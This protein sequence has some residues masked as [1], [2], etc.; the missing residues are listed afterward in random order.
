VGLDAY[1]DAEFDGASA[2][3]AGTCYWAAGRN[4]GGYSLF[5]ASGAPKAAL[6]SALVRPYPSLVAGALTSYEYDEN[7]RILTVNVVPDPSLTAPT[8][9]VIPKYVYPKG[10]TVDCGGCR[11][12]EADG[13]IR[14]FGSKASKVTVSPR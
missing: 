8:E 12:E 13:L 3:A 6:F 9:V 1:M 5:D 10:V 11:V 2:V 7:A 14:L 4:D